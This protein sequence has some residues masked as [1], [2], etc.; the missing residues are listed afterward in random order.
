MKPPILLIGFNRP[1]FILSRLLELSHNSL[2]P[3]MLILSI[4]GPR[5]D[6]EAISLKESLIELASLELPFA[7]E[8]IVRETNFGCSPHIILAVSE[9]LETY[10]E[11][12][13]LE[14]DVV[15]GEFFY[16][17]MVDGLSFI[18]DRNEF[19]TVG[20]FS[21]FYRK[22]W[23]V[24]Q[25]NYWRSTPYFSAWGWGTN[26]GFWSN[27][28]PVANISSLEEFLSVSD[29]WRSLEKRRQ[30]IWTPR[31]LRGVWDFNVQLSL[32]RESKLNLLPSLRV[33]ENEGFGDIRSTH[34]KHRRPWT[35]FGIGISNS[36]PSFKLIQKDPLLRR[37]FWAFTD[38]NLWAADGRFNSRARQV[39][40]RT[41]LRKHF[42]IKQNN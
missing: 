17:T 9:V 22:L 27:F 20:A 26:R 29:S 4:D 42:F 8:V 11:V 13:V 39:G 36:K 23:F 30:N 12:V 34:T 37:V 19:G 6:S 7:M 1:E 16:Q 25:K 2:L 28:V 3:D 35:L 40:I 24:S 15:P 31:F 32:F 41:F 5:N 21:P 10:E 38:S 33:I 18:R 14:D